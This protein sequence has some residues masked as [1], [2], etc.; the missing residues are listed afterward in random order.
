M[1]NYDE[2]K[3]LLL[4]FAECNVVGCV[5]RPQGVCCP[6]SHSCCPL[7]SVCQDGACLSPSDSVPWRQQLSTRPTATGF[8]VCPAKKV[9]CTDKQTCCPMQD[10]KYGCCP[11]VKVRRTGT[12]RV[13]TALSRSPA[14]CD[15]HTRY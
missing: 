7:H 5:S 3:P 12:R 8:H 9:A 2:I 1:H 14:G 13:D 10:G 11:L 4:L 15:R 6:G